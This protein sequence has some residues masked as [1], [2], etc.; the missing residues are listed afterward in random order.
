MLR[1]VLI[2]AL[3]SVAE[4]P[5]LP[6]KPRRNL[7]DILSEPPFA[8]SNLDIER[9]KDYPRPLGVTRFLLD[10][11]V[12]SEFSLTGKPNPGVSI[13]IRNSRPEA[14]FASVLTFAEILKGIELLPWGRR[15]SELE[16][17]LRIGVPDGLGRIA[18]DRSCC[19]PVG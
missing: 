6:L 18:C 17:W 2:G 14:L 15:R 8:G 16:S 9:Q 3:K 4:P 7:V 10:T 12:L 19:G 1:D 5:V 13:W 11:N